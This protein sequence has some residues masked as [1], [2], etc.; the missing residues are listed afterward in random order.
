MSRRTNYPHIIS[1]ISIWMN[2]YIV[3]YC[4]SVYENLII[5]TH[6]KFKVNWKKLEL[7]GDG[8]ARRRR[9]CEQHTH[10]HV[11]LTHT[12]VP[13]ARATKSHTVNGLT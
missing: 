10:T 4:S 9:Q 3:E 8:K 6:R 11:G 13:L 5:V 2:E 12:H 7:C 1:N